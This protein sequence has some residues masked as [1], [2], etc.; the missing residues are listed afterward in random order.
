MEDALL[1]TEIADEV[2]LFAVCDGHGGPEVSRFVIQNLPKTL[3]NDQDFKNRNYSKALTNTFK[4]L[5]EV[6]CSQRGE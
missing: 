5:D 4:K 3:S 2:Y 6:I 1:F